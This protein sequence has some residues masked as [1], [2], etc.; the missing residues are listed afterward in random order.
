MNWIKNNWYI[1]KFYISIFVPTIVAIISAIKT[2]NPMIGLITGILL[3]S[4]F[5]LIFYWKQL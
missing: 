3:A 5:I 4:I 2:N 1:I